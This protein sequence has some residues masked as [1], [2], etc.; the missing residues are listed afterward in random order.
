MALHANKEDLVAE[1]LSEYVAVAKI[2]IETDKGTRGCFGYPAA[3]ML[4]ICIDSIGSY[5]KGKDGYVVTIEG[6]EMKINGGGNKHYRILADKDFFDFEL[7]LKQIEKLYDQ[8]RCLLVHNSA[9]KTGNFLAV[10]ED[11]DPCF[12][13]GDDGNIKVVNLRPLQKSVAKSV[14]TFLGDDGAILKSSRQAKDI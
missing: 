12:E 4:F 6:K 8:Y 10:G 7:T 14:E 13:F 2:C 11:D 3:A 5:H 1:A 9:L